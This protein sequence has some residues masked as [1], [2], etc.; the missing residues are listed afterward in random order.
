MTL[1]QRITD[2]YARGGLFPIILQGLVAAGFDP[3]N[4]SPSDLAPVDEFH[5]G[6]RRATVAFAEQLAPAADSRLLDVGCGLGGATRF[7]AE[8]CQCHVTGVD[9]KSARQPR[10]GVNPV[11]YRDQCSRTFNPGASPVY[12]YH[13]GRR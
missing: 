4:L 13:C 6:G 3:D 9:L 2:H 11:D 12:R 7:F 10:R 1:N 5:I 8:K